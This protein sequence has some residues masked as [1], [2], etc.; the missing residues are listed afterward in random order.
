MLTPEIEALRAEW[1]DAWANA[2]R[3]YQNDELATLLPVCGSPIEQRLLIGL[4][5]M[6][7]PWGE[8][9]VS[10]RPNSLTFFPPGDFP[11]GR[12]L[13]EFTCSEWPNAATVCL[14]AEMPEA[15]GYRCDFLILAKFKNER[16]ATL[17][18][19]VECDGHEFHERTK[20]QAARDRKRDR[21]L[22]G[23]GFSILRFTGSEIYRSLPDCIS[24]IRDRIEAAFKA[25][26]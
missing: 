7:M 11:P 20:E 2:A 18:V 4:Y 14:Q 1:F 25:S 26:C 9:F 10:P 6:H 8:P 12:T 17:K 5:Y 19:V 13:A 15:G 23:A 24:E 16:A 22:Q 3:D 21:D